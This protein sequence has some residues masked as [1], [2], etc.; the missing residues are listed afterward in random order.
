MSSSVSEFSASPIWPS[1]PAVEPGAEDHEDRDAVRRRAE[2]DRAEQRERRDDHRGAGEAERG[3]DDAVGPPAEQAGDDHARA[4]EHDDVRGAH[5]RG[6]EQPPAE[7]GG[8]AE[9]PDDE[10]LEQPALGVAAHRAERQ[11]RRQHRAE[12][13]DREHRQAEHRRAGEHV[14]LDAELVDAEA[15]HV[16]EQLGRAPRVER[17]EDDAQHEHDEEDAAAQRL[18]QGV[19]GDEPHETAST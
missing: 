1:R 12:E 15:A 16:L 17:E 13:E 18:A 11:E 10:R 3:P 14:R 2:H 6:G 4:E 8:A 7:V 9:R 5:R 19:G